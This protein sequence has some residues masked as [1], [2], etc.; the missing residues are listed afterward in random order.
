MVNKKIINI[1]KEVEL[2]R[3]KEYQDT[4]IVKDLISL[5]TDGIKNGMT[6]RP[7]RNELDVKFINVVNLY[8]EDYIKTDL[9]EYVD[10]S[11]SVFNKYKVLKG[12]IFFT[13][14]SLKL[15]GIAHCNINIDSDS[16]LV[17]DDHIMRVRPNINLVNPYFLKLYC[18]SRVARK[19]F[20]SRA[21]TGTMT[22]IGQN[23]IADLPVRIPTMEEQNKISSFFSF[24]EKRIKKQEEKIEQ[25]KLF[26]KGMMQKIFLQKL[27][28][29]NENGE[30]FPKWR[31][32]PLKSIG[33]TYT[34][35]S[36]KSS[37]DFGVGSGLYITY[38]NVY[39]NVKAKTTG[40]E[41]VD[42]S[43]GKKQNQVL[44]GDILFTTSSEVPN[45][46]GMASYW[47][48]EE[49]NIYLNSFCFGYRLND[50][51]VLPEFLVY[52]LRSAEYRRKITLLAQGSTR[53]NLSKTELLKMNIEIPSVGE[54]Q[55]IIILLSGID[56]KLEKEE[57]KLSLLLKQKKG[58]MQQMFN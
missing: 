54:Q 7:G 56:K 53:F 55:K 52:L 58:F 43:D 26:K 4:P 19:F 48:A 14:S 42:L 29:K 47:G 35:L 21:K 12:D 50:E 31:H 8:D 40:I 23:D 20:M 46:V 36:G 44:K 10:I 39:A 13:R 38:K 11:E 25:V 32:K 37:K 5:S 28:F 9:L 24:L 49:Q 15:E 17:F 2:L 51:S 16:K 1:D 27:R 45:E 41:K 33:T 22:T 6:N 57:E 3:F 18:L 34:G 30:L